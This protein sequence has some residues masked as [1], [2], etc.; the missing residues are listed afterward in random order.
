MWRPGQRRVWGP[1]SGTHFTPH[2]PTSKCH[3]CGRGDQLVECSV[4]EAA[5]TAALLT[6]FEACGEWI[7]KEKPLRKP[8]QGWAFVNDPLQFPLA[9][10]GVT[11][12][13][14]YG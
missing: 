7:R 11:D 5:A 12:P 13:E 14:H 3:Q 6:P 4:D 1:Y 2:A 9:M 10:S 8:K